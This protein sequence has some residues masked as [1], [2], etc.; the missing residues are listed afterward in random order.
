[1][2]LSFSTTDSQKYK[3]VVSSMEEA[4]GPGATKDMN[5][6]MTKTELM[7]TGKRP[8]L[9]KL[10]IEMEKAPKAKENTIEKPTQ[11]DT[12]NFTK[13]GP[14]KSTLNNFM[15]KTKIILAKELEEGTVQVEINNSN[16]VIR[17]PERVVFSSGSEELTN[18]F[19][20]II[21]K[22]KKV[23]TDLPGSI[24]ISGH[25]DNRPIDTFRFRSNWELS[26]AR[27]VSVLHAVLSN[28]NLDPKRF[29]V[30]GHA[31]THPINLSNQAENRRVEISIRNEAP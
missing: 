24:T 17:F 31:D 25:T 28:S 18:Q 11:T 5:E 12:E 23:L 9:E 21:I 16:M 26:S 30:Q 15:K 20:P 2:M 3:A 1:M 14:E 29:T 8:T 10:P 4:F 27:A 13:T 19:D 6:L 22:L 7:N